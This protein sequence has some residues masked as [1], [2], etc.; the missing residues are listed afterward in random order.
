[1]PEQP[2]NTENAILDAIR[3]I[4][5]MLSRLDEKITELG[6]KTD[7]NARAIEAMRSD[8]ATLARDG[9]GLG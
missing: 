2:T 9:R 4:A 1:M 3:G 6:V 7:S 5:D 8:V